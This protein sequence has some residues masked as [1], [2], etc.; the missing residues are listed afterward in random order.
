MEAQKMLRRLYLKEEI[1]RAI[2]N[3][4]KLNL[5]GLGQ[6]DIDESDDRNI[7]YD[8]VLKN[9][10][11]GYFS[12]YETSSKIWKFKL[13][14]FDESGKFSIGYT[15]AKDVIEEFGKLVETRKPIQFACF[16]NNAHVIKMYDKM[17][18]KFGGTKEL[19][20]ESDHD[21]CY[22]YRI[23]FDD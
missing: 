18:A 4:N 17:C 14:C 22:R 11:I 21:K 6:L 10:V 2:D 1:R 13:G 23:N 3:L 19:I 15:I 9:A 8:I 7:V 5:Q 20:E 16:I 12:Y